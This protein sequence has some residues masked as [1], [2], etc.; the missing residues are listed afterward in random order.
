MY[1]CTAVQLY[2]LHIH[3]HV[4]HITAQTSLIHHH[5]LFRFV[6]QP[7]HIRFIFGIPV[8]HVLVHPQGIKWILYHAL[9]QYKLTNNVS[10]FLQHKHCF[11]LFFGEMFHGNAPP[12]FFASFSIQ[13]SNQD[14]PP[15]F[16][17]ALQS[18]P[19][20]PLY[21]ETF[22]FLDHVPFSF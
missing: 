13:S 16:N 7:P 1:T 6:Q 4:D 19:P 11:F 18:G 20:P 22:L 12:V 3:I 5:P 10:T 14:V 17:V 8:F 21:L 2:L 15:I 9:P